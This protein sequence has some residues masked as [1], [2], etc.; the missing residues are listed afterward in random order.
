[1]PFPQVQCEECTTREQPLPWTIK[2]AERIDAFDWGVEEDSRKTL[3]VRSSQ[4]ILKE[5]NPE[6]SLQGLKLQYFGHLM[7]RTDSLEKTLMLGKIEGRRRREQQRWDG[8]MALPTQWTGVWANSKKSEREAWHAAVHGVSKSRTQIS[9]W[10]TK[11]YFLKGKNAVRYT[12]LITMRY[13][14]TPGRMA[15]IKETKCWRGWWESRN[16]LLYWWEYNIV[17]PLWITIKT[18]NPTCVDSPKIHEN[19]FTWTCLWTFMAAFCVMAPNWKL[20]NW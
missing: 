5:V 4:S 17:Q 15:V 3:T 8:W 2:K 6:Y 13:H 14:F 12:G 20:I 11:N 16:L 18:S 19:M 7:R 9:D 10:T 1:M